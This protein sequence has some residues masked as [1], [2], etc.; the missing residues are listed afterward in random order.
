M[1]PSLRAVL[2]FLY[3]KEITFTSPS[4]ATDGAGKSENA[5]EFSASAKSVYLAADKVLRIPSLLLNRLITLFQYDIPELK[6]LALDWIRTTTHPSD[7]VQ[8]LTS[9]FTAMYR[10]RSFAP[11]SK[12][13]RCAETRF[14]EIREVCLQ[15]LANVLCARDRANITKELMSAILSPV[16]PDF[17]IDPEI[18]GAIFDMLIKGYTRTNHTPY[19]LPVSSIICSAPR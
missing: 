4:S 1:S 8:E 9:E 12:L 19:V 7:I 3:T 17:S 13:T 2:I 11:I 16:T 18:K 10:F 14:P 15:L 6:A 5:Q